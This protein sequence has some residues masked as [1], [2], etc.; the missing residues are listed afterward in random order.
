[1]Q[2]QLTLVDQKHD[3]EYQK[4]E[5]TVLAEHSEVG[6]DELQDFEV[7]LHRRGR[8]VPWRITVR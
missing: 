7:F 3:P 4:G 2:T 1:M 5:Y 8:E 6:E